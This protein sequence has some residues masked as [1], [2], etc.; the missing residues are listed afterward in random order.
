METISIFIC[1]YEVSLIKSFQIDFLFDCIY[2]ISAISMCSMA[3]GACVCVC[4]KCIWQVTCEVSAM[5][6]IHLI[7]PSNRKPY[8]TTEY[9]HF[10]TI[11]CMK[12]QCYCWCITYFF[13]SLYNNTVMSLLYTYIDNMYTKNNY[14][15]TYL[16][17]VHVHLFHFSHLFTSKVYLP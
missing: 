4:E 13:F 12:P 7:K 17:H 3:V 14:M 2:F 6:L 16:H 9:Q 10:T 8:V 1:I 5:Q 11:L 15:Y